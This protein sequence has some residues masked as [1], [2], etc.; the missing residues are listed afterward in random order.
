MTQNT[1]DSAEPIRVYYNGACPICRAEIQHY[2]KIANR[3]EGAA[4]GWCDVTGSPGTLAAIGVDD[5]AAIRRLHVV[6]G[7]GRLLAGVE[8][9]IAIWARLPGY[10]WLA[11]IAAVS[12]IKPIA[13]VLYDN[14]LAAVLYRWNKAKG[15]VPPVA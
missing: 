11:R 9:F 1:A 6:D 2:Q 4:L 12:W 15:R 7:E 3:H 5:D 10:R 14:V 13:H 8:A